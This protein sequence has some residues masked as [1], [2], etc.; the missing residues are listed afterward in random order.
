M[1]TR[2]AER[3]RAGL[4]EDERVAAADMDISGMAFVTPA[5]RAFLQRRPSWRLR[6]I[7]AKRHIL[8]LYENAVRGFGADSL[9]AQALGHAVAALAT[10][11]QDTPAES[12]PAHTYLSTSCLHATEPG[13]EELHTYCQSTTGSNGTTEWAKAPASCKFCGAPCTCRCH[14]TQDTQADTAT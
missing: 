13:R 7:A 9:S 3:L 2:D 6:D 12:T 14:T 10:V 4:D 5:G 1:S 8:A 11:Y